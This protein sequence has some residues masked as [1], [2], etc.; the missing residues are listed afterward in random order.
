MPIHRKLQFK[1][2]VDTVRKG[3]RKEGFGMFFK[4]LWICCLGAFP[5]NAVRFC[6][7]EQLMKLL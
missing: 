3:Y 7:H 2:I 1:A 5:K 4:G 6:A